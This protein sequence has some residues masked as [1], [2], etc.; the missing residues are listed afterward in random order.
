MM[1]LFSLS[2]NLDLVLALEQTELARAQCSAKVD[3][4]IKIQDQNNEKAQ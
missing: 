1:P 3:S 2:I 4:I